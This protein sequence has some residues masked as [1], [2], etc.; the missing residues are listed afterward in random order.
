[1]S[2]KYW[3]W[4]Q[5][6][7]DDKPRG[8]QSLDEWQLSEEDAKIIADATA[9]PASDSPMEPAA[10]AATDDTDPARWTPADAVLCGLH[11]RTNP[12]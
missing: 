6:T 11:R 3:D 4:P 7:P 9:R 12:P 1:M 2:R 10:S 8:I 5:R